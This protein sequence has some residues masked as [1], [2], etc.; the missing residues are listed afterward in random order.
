MRVGVVT[1]ATM[2]HV[3]AYKILDVRHDASLQ[4]IKAAYRKQAKKYH[5]DL[6]SSSEFEYYNEKMQEINEAYEI[7]KRQQ[8]QKAE[9]ERQARE[10]QERERQ[11]RAQREK[12]Q[13][14]EQAAAQK[15][16]AEEKARQ[17]HKQKTE[18]ERQEREKQEQERQEQA[19]REKE[20]RE[21]Q[22]QREKERQEAEQRARDAEAAKQA[23]AAAQ[24]AKEAAEREAQEKAWRGEQARKAAAAKAAK[25]ANEEAAAAQKAKETAEREAQEKAQREEQ[26]QQAAI[27]EQKRQAAKQRALD[28]MAAKQAQTAAAAAKRMKAKLRRR[29]VISAA[30]AFLL[31]ILVYQ[32]FFRAVPTGENLMVGNSIKF[33]SI[34][35]EVLDVQEGKAL[36]LASKSVGKRGYDIDN[37]KEYGFSETRWDICTLRKWLN[38]RFIK[39]FNQKERE[40]IVPVAIEK[41]SE[42]DSFFILSYSEAKKYKVS[43]LEKSGKVWLR[44]GNG[45]HLGRADGK[46]IVV[47][48][49]SKDIEGGRAYSTA[50]NARLE[51]YPAFWLSIN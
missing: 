30:T 14:E 10:K 6:H 25:K 17:E 29:I 32:Q 47:E 24:R 33:G 9:Q 19:R 13:R 39:R 28:E 46:N 44:L 2:T 49:Y 20:Q 15:A 40:Q 34:T 1:T 12:K 3:T 45:A 51:V 35:W 36:L 31:S 11:E 48:Y 38:S 41:Q 16:K 42:M 21:E 7:L 43:F 50:F 5:P 37:S 18:Q 27:A 26:A 22:A 4:E 8:E 23:Q